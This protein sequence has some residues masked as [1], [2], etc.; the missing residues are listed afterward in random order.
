M[1]AAKTVKRGD[2]R[3]DGAGTVSGR[4]IAL[5]LGLAAAA[6]PASPALPA[7][8]AL[9]LEQHGALR[10]AAAFAIVAGEQARGEASAL[11]YPPL[12]ARG[13][14]F[15]VATGARVIDEAHIDRAQLQAALAG[16]VAALQHQAIVAGKPQQTLA[17]VM[18]ACLTML[19][20]TVPP[21]SVPTLPQCTAIMTL[22]ADEVERQPRAAGPAKDLRTLQG[23]LSQRAR[24][25]L[26]GEGKTTYETDRIMTETREAMAAGGQ[27][28]AER[29]DISVC[30]DLAQPAADPHN[31]AGAAGH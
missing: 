18:P 5:L 23:V 16:E 29:Y 12:A 7:P 8:R 25:A 19:A 26:V 10:C 24:A 21:L 2:A 17:A 11:A 9:S 14:A 6:E 28:G 30:Y 27:A 22:A 3:L 13:K 20:A 31:A 1:H 4:M 15:F